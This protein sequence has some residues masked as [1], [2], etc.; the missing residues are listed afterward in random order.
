[1]T[2]VELV[3]LCAAALV[4]IWII[5]MT[6]AARKPVDWQPPRADRYGIRMS[7]NFYLVAGGSGILVGLAM[8]IASFLLFP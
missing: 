3:R 5:Q 6:W 8:F 2:G 7:R 1:M 4:V